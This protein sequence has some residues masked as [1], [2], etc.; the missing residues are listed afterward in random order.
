MRLKLALVLLATTAATPALA[1]DIPAISKVDAVTVFPSGAEVT[2]LSE[3]RLDA[4]EH[5]LIFEGLPGDLM[6]ETIR[7]EGDGGGQIE[8]G[9][10][11]ARLAYLP[12]TEI[13]AQRK[14]LEAMIQQLN[15]ERSALEQKITDAEYQKNLMQELASNAFGKPPKEGEPKTFGADDLGQ[16]LDLVGGRLQAIS[17]L[18]IDSR[19]RQREIDIR[20]NDLNVQMTELAPRDQARMRVAVHLA[21]PVATDGTF[22]L[23]YRIAGAGWQPIYDARLTSPAK[24]T[25]AKI[26]LVRRAAVT[27]STTETWD[28]VALTLSTARPVGATAAPEMVPQP[29]D[30]YKEGRAENYQTRGNIALQAPAPA[31][32]KLGDVAE[33]A[34]KSEVE[35]KVKKAQQVQA[36]VQVAGFQALYAIPGRVS[37]DNTGTAKNVRIS[38]STLE[39]KLAA[40]A[41]PKLDPNAYMTAGFTLDGE[42]PILPG[43]AM[44]YRDGVYMGQGWLPMLSPGEEAKLG[45][46]A[47]DL[48]KVKRV[49]VKRL[50]S[51]EGII[52]SSNVDT[53][54]YDITVKN[55]HDFAVPVTVLDQMPYSTHE[56]IEITTLPGMTAPTAKDFEKK[57]GVLA[58]SFELAPKDEKVVKH[59]FKVTW[60]KDMVV[61][62][63]FN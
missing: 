61:G 27:Q 6:A 1:A 21:A 41:V 42:T 8:I 9:S 30:A 50:L 57:R 19:L 31:A 62:M 24:S 45:F 40:R 54:A 48:I 25:A 39:A 43:T 55:L 11:D 47:D 58:W 53:R 59:G 36:D 4:G 33:D 20:I 5:T 60:P 10:V 26:E 3:V 52:S 56:D 46:G 38:T 37:I 44:L 13:D 16:L 18:I 32:E 12:S 17:K 63:T 14:S 34:A 49:E 28:G 29:I 7:I 23:K 35:A 2:R 15:D 51:E 22:R